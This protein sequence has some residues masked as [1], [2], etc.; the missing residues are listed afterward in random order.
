MSF[1]APRWLR[2]INVTAD[3]GRSSQV[4]AR[5]VEI[6]AD[7]IAFDT[8]SNR[9]N[10][11]LVG[12]VKTLL[13]KC[14]VGVEVLPDETGQKANLLASVGP[15]EANGIILSGHTDVVPVDGQFW[16]T[17]PFA[18]TRQGNRLYGRGTADMKSF[19]ACTLAVVETADLDRLERPVYLAF[20]YDEE[21]GCLGAPRLIEKLVS[22][23]AM[24]AVV[25]VGEP[26]RMRIIGS[27]KSMHLFKVSVTGVAA[28]SSAVHQGVSANALAIRLMSILINIADTLATSGPQ[29]P[30]F[31]PPFATLTIGTMK[32]GTAANILAAEADFVFDLRCLPDQLPEEILRPFDA[33][34]D[35]LREAHPTASIMIETLASVPPLSSIGIEEAE[36]LVRAVS[37]DNRE[38]QTGSYGAEAGQFQQA[39]FQTVICGPGSM[40]QGHQPDE[41][42]EL[43]EIDK[44]VRFLDQLF[45]LIRQP[46]LAA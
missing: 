18:L 21:V 2:I 7:L 3:E 29:D 37:G 24:P 40:D 46:E 39:G 31:E 42:V 33:E 26:S 38:I 12:Y 22:S 19:L 44:C 10:L 45:A 11:A 25:I 16:N 8:V 30:A 27:H 28:H 9:S 23:I 34:V 13:E 41:F 4:S 5:A 32:G 43:G 15:H 20:S 36:R 1:F 35:S 6:L 14:G 17:D